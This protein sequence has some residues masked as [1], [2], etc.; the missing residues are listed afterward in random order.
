M[1]HAI[2]TRHAPSSSRADRG[3]VAPRTAASAPSVYHDETDATRTTP[4]VEAPARVQV[5]GR[6]ASSPRVIDVLAALD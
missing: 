1:R 3:S 4:A 5:A 6:S 2:V